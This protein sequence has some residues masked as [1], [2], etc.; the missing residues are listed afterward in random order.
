MPT[1]RL[2]LRAGLR[3]LAYK[4]EVTTV[5]IISFPTFGFWTVVWL[6]IR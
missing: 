1:F 3:F 5:F 6:V 4:R 2:A